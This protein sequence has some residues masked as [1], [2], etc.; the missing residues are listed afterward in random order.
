[1]DSELGRRSG[2]HGPGKGN[3]GRWA[4]GLPGQV[5]SDANCPGGEYSRDMCRE[6]EN[7]NSQH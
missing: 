2:S 5:W 7:R 3:G 4:R 1:L 6:S